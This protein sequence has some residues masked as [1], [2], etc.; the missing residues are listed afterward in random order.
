M[1]NNEQVDNTGLLFQFAGEVEDLKAQ[2]KYKQAQLE[3]VLIQ[4]GVN[5]YHQD[6]INDV[7]YKIYVPEGT[8]VS[9][10]KI[11]VKRTNLPGEKNT[12]ALSKSEAQE[13]GF[14][15]SK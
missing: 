6:P 11:A 14:V 15:V 2:L 8:F 7:V 10:P 4:L 12:N 13:Q 5:T 3:Q 9:F 1:E